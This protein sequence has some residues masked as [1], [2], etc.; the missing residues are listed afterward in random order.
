MAEATIIYYSKIFVNHDHLD[1]EVVVELKV[2]EV[3][4]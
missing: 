1:S 2:W 3:K 4:I